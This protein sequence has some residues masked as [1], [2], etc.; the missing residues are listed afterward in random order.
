M[1]RFPLFRCLAA[2]L[3]SSSLCACASAEDPR[4]GKDLSKLSVRPLSAVETMPAQ[5]KTLSE[6]LVKDG[7]DDAY[8]DVLYK[9]LTAPPLSTP[10]GLKVTELYSKRFLPKPSTRP[11]TRVETQL[12]IPGPWFKGMVTEENA[13]KCRQFINENAL[14]FVRAE[15]DYQVPPEIGAALLFVETR[16]GTFMGRHNPLLTL[17]SMAISRSPE[18]IAEYLEKLKGFEKHR[19]WIRDVMKTKAE[20]AYKELKALLEYCHANGIDP[21]ELPGS[22]YGAIG[23]CQFMPSNLEKFARDGNQDG[24]INIF[25]PDDAIASLSNY[26]S[27][28]GWKDELPLQKKVKVL[29]T[30]NPMDTYALTILALAKTI[31]ELDR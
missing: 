24:I 25:H 26:L 30:Y 14:S 22:V 12:G 3:L 11:A 7:L 21:L 2:L 31:K 16:L 19:P 29:R 1:P 20:W 6:R 5:W 8:V 18:Q 15:L 27:F 13:R 9:N 23:M 4:S 17:S 10:M 28:Y